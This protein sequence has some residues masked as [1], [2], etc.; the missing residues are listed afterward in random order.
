MSDEQTPPM[1]RREALKVMAAAAASASLAEG[2]TPAVADA[3]Q[4]VQITPRRAAAAPV[5]PKVGPRGTPTDPDTKVGL[6]TRL[7]QIKELPAKRLD[8]QAQRLQ[9]TTEIFDS[10]D[11]QRK[12]REE[13]F[14]PV[15][16]LIR[17]NDLI[18]EDYRLQFQATLAA[19]A[20]TIA[21]RTPH[22]P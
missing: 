19:S 11:A 5:P 6:E 13:L 21:E 9:L 4:P 1:D 22:R 15:Q 14:K 17:A 12:A 16:D 8:L 2:L 3:Q 10:L 20:E 7:A 18:R